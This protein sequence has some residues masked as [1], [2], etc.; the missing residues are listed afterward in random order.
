M[1]PAFNAETYVGQAIESIL[2]Q[3]NPNWE[4]V[5][6]DD[7]SVDRTR[8][9]ASHY[10]DT[11]IQ[12]I[13]QENGGESIARNTAIKHVRGEFLAFLDADDLYL[14]N[15][16]RVAAEYLTSQPQVNGVYTDGYYIDQTGKQLQ[17]LS[18]RRRGPFEGDLFE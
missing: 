16:L 17:T 6:V 11:R 15:H 4:L 8:D 13:H 7:G 1:M 10:K 3:T 9:I 14:P 12:V 5:I 2:A 18:S